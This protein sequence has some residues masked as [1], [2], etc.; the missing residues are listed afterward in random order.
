M[1]SLLKNKF[2][3]QTNGLDF[4]RSI[5]R[6][7]KRHS[8]NLLA[9]MIV[10]VHT[11]LLYPGDSPEWNFGCVIESAQLISTCFDNIYADVV[12]IWTPMRLVMTDWNE[13]LG[14]SHTQA[15]TINRS[16]TIPKIPQVNCQTMLIGGNSI[17]MSE[18]YLA[19]NYLARH[20]GFRAEG[21]DINSAGV[22]FPADSIFNKGVSA[23]PSRVYELNWNTFFRNENIQAPILIDKTSTFGSHDALYAN[24]MGKLQVANKLKTWYYCATPA[25]SLLDVSIAMDAVLPVGFIA[26]HTGTGSN[27]HAGISSTYSLTKD[28]FEPLKTYGDTYNKDLSV[29]VD[30]AQL[31]VNRMYYALMEQ[32]FANKMMKGRRAV[33]FYQNFFGV[34]DSDAGHDLPQLICQKR[35]P[36]NISA[37]ISTS[38]GTNGTSAEDTRLGQR[39]AFSQTGFGDPL[40]NNFTATEHGYIQTYLIIRGQPSLATGIDHHLAIDSLLDTYIPEF[41]HIGPVGIDSLEVANPV[42]GYSAT[43]FGYTNAWYSERYQTSDCVGIIAPGQP[44]AYK[45]LAIDFNPGNPR[46]SNIVISD[47]VI[48]F[49]PN[50]MDRIFMFPVCYGIP[51]TSGYDDKGQS[52]TSNR[53]QFITQ[54]VVKG[55]TAKVMSP[56]SEP[57]KLRF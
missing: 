27:I 38:A 22:S 14:E 31:S 21:L 44:L 54:F 20:L 25:P 15:F 49:Q 19:D 34:R 40:I 51:N 16:I 47:A 26:D 23:L 56:D 1:S 12:C 4:S 9:G 35:Y 57:L 5:F 24:G 11:Q 29:I 6:Y 37:V 46:L 17:T 13:F 50:I 41:D 30:T 28:A 48:R 18:A 8:T 32:R 53:Y 55:K 2:V 33:E 45:T 39:G 43:N 10:P 52:Y 3:K 36:L 7:E 42:N